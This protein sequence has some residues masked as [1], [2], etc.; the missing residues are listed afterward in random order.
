V[1]RARRSTRN[2]R[3]PSAIE[4]TTAS[5]GG[6]RGSVVSPS[7]KTHCQSCRGVAKS[8]V[9]RS[10]GATCWGRPRCCLLVAPK[11]RHRGGHRRPRATRMWARARDK[12]L[13]LP[14]RTR[15]QFSLAWR[16]A[17]RAPLS[18]REPHPSMLTPR[19][20][21]R[22][23]RLPPANFT[24]ALIAPTR[25][26]CRGIG[27]GGSRRT[28]RRHRA[29][30]RQWSLAPPRGACS[31]YLTGAAE[32]RTSMFPRRRW[33]QRTNSSHCRGRRVSPRADQGACCRR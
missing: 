23:D 8:P 7:M 21:R 1:P 16:P 28:R 2:A 6:R 13:T 25:T 4:M 22:R 29:H 3:S 10:T 18:H 32:P 31:R 9:R 20:G 15:G 33:G 24:M 14:V 26:P 5:R 19:G 17:G 11:C 27:R 12:Q 30:R